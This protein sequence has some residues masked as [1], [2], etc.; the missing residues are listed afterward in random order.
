MTPRVLAASVLLAAWLAAC[1][2]KSDGG[3]GVVRSIAIQ[4]QAAALCV[5][6]SV[7]MTGQARDA[8]GQPVSGIGL[9]W[10][11][12][13]PEVI[14]VGAAT[15]VARALATGSSVITASA[16]GVTS[17]GANLDAP[18]DLVPEF[19]PDSALLAPGDTMTLGVRLRRAS[20]GPVP[21]RTPVFTPFDSAVASLDASG[22]VHAKK[23]G[24]VSLSV[25][26]C[27]RQGGGQVE[28]FTPTDAVTGKA[29]LWL[30]GP[31]ELRFRLPARV[32]NF[33]RTG[34]QPAFQVTSCVGPCTNPTRLFV[35][36]D[37]V[38]LSATGGYP[39]DSLNSME[40]S[41]TLACSPPRPFALYG[42]NSPTAALVSMRGGSAAVTR[43]A[44]QSGYSAVSGRLLL[45]MR[46]VVL[47]VLTQLDTLNVIY[48][49]SA[50]L[51]DSTGA[52]P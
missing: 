15:G 20:N 41:G 31:P 1:S 29:Y 35:Y 46:G 44:P 49:F 8:G 18:A 19:V 6:D 42:D 7:T 17:S 27:G 28:V 2:S 40:A 9:A 24:S 47:G 21:A 23:V 13:A 48:M 34:G 14:G 26:A 16:Q 36:E 50:P 30:S 22:T 3:P 10:A 33:T 45:R 32:I 39:L 38:H 11:S 52:C 51:V 5:G 25:S 43:L 4:P 12:S 37:T